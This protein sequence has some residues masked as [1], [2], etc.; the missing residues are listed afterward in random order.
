MY[1]PK[2][3]RKSQ[4]ILFVVCVFVSFS[5]SIFANPAGLM[6]DV[7]A[8][9][10]LPS[11]ALRAP[12]PN[13]WEKGTR[14]KSYP[15]NKVVVF[16][17]SLSDNG[18]LYA[19]MKQQLPISPP[20]FAGRFTNGLV[21]V[22]Q[23]TQM[24]YANDWQS[25]LL[26]Y[27]FGSA[28]VLVMRDEDDS[29]FTL[30][31][32]IDSYLLAHQNHAD[33]QSLFIIW[34]GANNYLAVPDDA[35]RTVSEV[36]EG[37]KRN[38]QR[39]VAR[40]AQHI[41]V[42]NLPDLGKTPVAQEFEAVDALTYFSKQHNTTLAKNMAQL[43]I[44]NPDVQWLLFDAAQL[45]DHVLARPTQYGFT[46]T[47][48]TC[49]DATINMPSSQSVLNLV[50]AIQSHQRQKTNTCQG[51]FFIDPIHPSAAVHQFMAKQIA[52]FLQN[53]GVSV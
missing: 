33:E 13:S 22:E 5:I 26:D 44:D 20:Y 42:I 29:V 32:E 3:L 48:Q 12:S 51:Y 40:G 50:T 41:L 39:L 10:V 45:F 30:D 7:K 21:W 9:L 28:D 25:H 23:L 52:V 24:L 49:Y 15:I 38:L 27:A 17:D 1:S 46:N 14:R 43:Q 34:I 35:D 4:V 31:R 47:T 19:Y 53:N 16:G 2:Q 36:N 11:S 6:K 37:I 8:D 18:N